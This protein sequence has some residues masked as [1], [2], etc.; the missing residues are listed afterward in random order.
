MLLYKTVFVGA[1]VIYWIHLFIYIYLYCKLNF[2]YIYSSKNAHCGWLFIFAWPE[3][4]C[5][6]QK[7]WSVSSYILTL[8][9]IYAVFIR[10]RFPNSKVKEM[11][12]KQKANKE[13]LLLACIRV[14]VHL[15]W[16][17]NDSKFTKGLDCFKLHF[18]SH[19]K[20]WNIC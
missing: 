16:T 4:I 10:G 14:T 6:S 1:F 2:I 12:I 19:I 9:Q 20:M 13:F 8:T 15:C 5:S 11:K 7:G 3:M 17:R 18:D